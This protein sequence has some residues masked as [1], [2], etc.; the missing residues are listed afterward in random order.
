MTPPPATDDIPTSSYNMD[1]QFS[2]EDLNTLRRAATITSEMGPARGYGYSNGG[3]GL[4]GGF[5]PYGALGGR[6]GN[7]N[8]ASAAVAGGLGSLAALAGGDS[9]GLPGLATGKP[10]GAADTHQM[11]EDSWT[12]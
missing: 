10:A 2:L 8:A 1:H 12:G 7:N 5:G 4:P 9:W 3:L 11:W 6:P